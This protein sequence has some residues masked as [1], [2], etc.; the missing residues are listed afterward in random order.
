MVLL[1]LYQV[2][3]TELWAGSL[4]ERPAVFTVVEHVLDLTLIM[5]VAVSQLVPVNLKKKVI[6]NNN[7]NT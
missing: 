2:R 1:C 4:D 3:T 7:N 6:I 5:R